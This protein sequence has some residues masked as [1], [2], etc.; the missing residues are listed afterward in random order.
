MPATVFL[1][2]STAIFS[3]NRTFTTL[4]VFK[5]SI[6]LCPLYSLLTTSSSSSLSS[7]ILSLISFS[8]SCCSVLHKLN[9]AISFFAPFIANPTTAGATC[10]TLYN[11]LPECS[12]S[13]N[14]L[15]T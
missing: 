10:T 9:L 1:A 5:S 14:D 12:S 4:G 6:T 3:R 15:V 7:L 11:Q 13:L 2:S 8:T